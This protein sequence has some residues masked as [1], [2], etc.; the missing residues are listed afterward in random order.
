MRKF[1]QSNSS[2]KIQYGLVFSFKAD[3]EYTESAIPSNWGFKNVEIIPT[4]NKENNRYIITSVVNGKMRQDIEHNIKSSLPNDFMSS[5]ASSIPHKNNEDYKKNLPQSALSFYNKEYKKYINTQKQLSL[6]SINY[7]L[8]KYSNASTFLS[9]AFIDIT[10][11]NKNIIGEYIYGIIN[12][13]N[14]LDSNIEHIEKI[15]KDNNDSAVNAL[16]DGRDANIYSN[17]YKI[18][19]KST[20]NTN[21][22][23]NYTTLIEKDGARKK[24]Y[25]NYDFNSMFFNYEPLE[26]VGILNKKAII[27]TIISYKINTVNV[28]VDK[29]EEGHITGYNCGTPTEREIEYNRIVYTCI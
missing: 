27:K 29:D 16:L 20:Y 8:D 11:Y 23:I 19:Y 26:L 13:S 21:T 3:I 17:K 4:Q 12:G 24:L 15:I 22:I 10:L 28:Y 1:L 7:I 18:F 14:T 6:I 2:N 25:F 9:G 5:D